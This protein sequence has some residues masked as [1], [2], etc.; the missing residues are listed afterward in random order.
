MEECEY[1]AYS[2]FGEIVWDGDTPSL[3]II[4]NQDIQDYLWISVQVSNF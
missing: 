1:L 2:N 3:K 4:G